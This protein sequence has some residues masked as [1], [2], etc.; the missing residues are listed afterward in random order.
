[1]KIFFTGII[2]F[3]FSNLILGQANVSISMNSPSTGANL[4]A[5]S[6]INFDFTISNTGS[7][8]IDAQDTI[9]LLPTANR[10]RIAKDGPSPDF[11]E[12]ILNVDIPANGGSYNFS[13]SIVVKG[14]VD[15]ML[16]F[17]GNIKVFGSG[18]RGVVETDLL[19]NQSCNEVNWTS[20]PI[21]LTEGSKAEL[22]DN[23][24][25]QKGVYKIRLMN[26][27]PNQKISFELVNLTG[28]I[29]Q[30]YTFQSSSADVSKDIALAAP[31]KGIYIA[32]LSSKSKALS[33]KKIVV[34]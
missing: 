1:M 12:W 20:M 5:G 18:W 23:S 11:V 26:V 21:S 28:K 27:D 30:S 34:H 32:R 17:C 3:I 4:S 19:D 22:I 13:E 33:I 25:Y 2:I 9:I 24:Y 16:D 6:N 10:N 14:G 8:P 7:E 15:G 29:I 31:P